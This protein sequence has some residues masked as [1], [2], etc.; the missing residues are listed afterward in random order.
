MTNRK[1]GFICV[2]DADM[3]CAVTE[4]V[5]G[6]TQVKIWPN[7]VDAYREHCEDIM[8]S[9]Q[10]RMEDALAEHDEHARIYLYRSVMNADT[11]LQD[12]DFYEVVEQED[13]RLMCV[14]FNEL[15]WEPK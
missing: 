3:E 6:K 13:G 9:F 14:D 10:T 11:P 8:Q 7:L 1:R 4:V 2:A 15:V 12:Y 5:N